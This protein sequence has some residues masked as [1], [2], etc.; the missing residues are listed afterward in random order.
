ME[1]LADKSHSTFQK[2]IFLESTWMATRK[3]TCSL[4]AV[5]TAFAQLLLGISTLD[6]F[7]PVFNDEGERELFVN[8]K[9]SLM[10]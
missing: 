9:V 5:P 4:I 10:A 8:I 2:P 1:E 7:T 6:P 3:S